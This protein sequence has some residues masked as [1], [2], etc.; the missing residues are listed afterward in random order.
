MNRFERRHPDLADL[1]AEWAE[2]HPDGTLEDGVRDLKLW[3]NPKDRDAQW[4]VWRYLP[5]GHPAKSS[6]AGESL[7]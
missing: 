2:D 1:V 3:H 6:L 5:D 7:E 4:F